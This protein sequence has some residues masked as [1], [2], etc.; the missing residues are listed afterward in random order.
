MRTFPVDAIERHIRQ[1]H[2]GCPDFAVAYFALEVA[3]KEWRDARLGKAV[4]ITM[5][6]FLRHEMTDYDT[7]LL[8]GM[9]R[10]EARARVQPR[11]DVMLRVW[12]RRSGAVKTKQAQEV[13]DV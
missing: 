11:I 5:Q 12:R 4:G 1:N 10:R 3:Q 7:L 6:N 13:G 2:P 9:D 8:Q